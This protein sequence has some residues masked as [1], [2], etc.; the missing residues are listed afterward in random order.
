[1]T[2]QVNAM[3]IYTER[4]QDRN[5]FTLIELLVVIAIIAILA[6]LLLPALARAKL[7]AQGTYCMNNEKQIALAIQMYAADFTEWFPMNPDD[8]GA[9]PPWEWCGGDVHGPPPYESTTGAQTFDPDYLRNNQIVPVGTY[10]GASIDIWRCPADPRQG[11]YSGSQLSLLGKQVKVTRSVSMLSAV[12]SEDQGYAA[13]G[14]H[15]GGTTYTSGSWLDG[16][17]HGNK[18]NAPWATFSKMSDFGRVGSSDIFM[19]VDESPYSINDACLGVCADP[20]QAK[21]VDWPATTH[22]GACG[23]GFCDGHAEIHKWK[24][25]SM[26]LT[27]PANTQSVPP[28]TLWY[29]DWLWLSS[30]ASIRMN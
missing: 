25:G 14:G 10:M 7:K 18:H 3:K 2:S 5:G 22:G 1:L 29:T 17:Q 30:H 4:L 13:G 26:T 21:I 27:G 12:G 19:T 9:T 15:S 20:T 16:T 24:S 23:F 6:A 28:G 11:Q 8:G